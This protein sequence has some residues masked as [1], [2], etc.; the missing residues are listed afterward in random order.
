[1]NISNIIFGKNFKV[2]LLALVIF[3][4]K[5]SNILPEKCSDPVKEAKPK[6][7]DTFKEAKNSVVQIITH[8]E[9]FNWSRPD[10]AGNQFSSAGSGFFINKDGDI[11]TNAHVVDHA[12]VIYIK[13]PNLKKEIEVEIKA[14]NPEVDLAILGISEESKEE[15]LK[16]LEKNDVKEI[17]YLKIGSSDDLEEGETVA[18][19]GFPLGQ[20]NIKIS[21]GERA[22]SHTF[23]GQ[24]FIQTTTPIN[25]GNSGGPMINK[26]GEVVGISTCGIP[27]AQN[28]GYFIPISD[29]QNMINDI[30][31]NKYPEKLLTHARWGLELQHTTLETLKY[32]QCPSEEGIRIKKIT[33]SFFADKIGLKIGDIIH[34]IKIKN[35]QFDIDNSGYVDVEWLQEGVPFFDLIYRLGIEEEFEIFIFRPS[36]DDNPSEEISIKTHLPIENNLCINKKYPFLDEEKPKY[37]EIG[38][39]IIMELTENHLGYL[40]EG[41]KYGVKKGGYLLLPDQLKYL[42]LENREKSRL[43]ITYIESGTEISNTKGISAGDILSKINNIPVDTLEDLVQALEISQEDGTLVIEVED[44]DLVAIPWEKIYENYPEN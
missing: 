22:G 4:L 23:D 34:A 8:S 18:A 44:G 25:P 32:L 38:G 30:L 7:S 12:K 31:N 17:S 29:V 3:S 11:I 33:P 15:F 26:K 13:T 19:L 2:I 5:T 43:G 20:K 24:T 16:N 28:I 9:A 39:M 27:S 36:I 1:M 41:I 21:K 10:Q 6:W 40:V 37:L 35:E 42:K 14:F